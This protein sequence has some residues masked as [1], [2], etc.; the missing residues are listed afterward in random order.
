MGN[1][2]LIELD[3][4]EAEATKVEELVFVEVSLIGLEQIIVHQRLVLREVAFSSMVSD[5][6]HLRTIHPGERIEELPDK[7]VRD[8]HILKVFVRCCLVLLTPRVKDALPGRGDAAKVDNKV[9][10]LAKVLIPWVVLNN[11][12]RNVWTQPPVTS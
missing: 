8:A 12:I 1:P 7:L 11:V 5:I 9:Q 4:D 6:V 3:G 10:I 2:E